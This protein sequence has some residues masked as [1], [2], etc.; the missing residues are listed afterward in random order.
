MPI[1]RLR[2]QLTGAA[3]VTLVLTVL[4]AVPTAWGQDVAG[5][6]EPMVPAK[7]IFDVLRQLLHKKSSEKAP[8]PAV[9][10]PG[11]TMAAYAPYIAANSSN[12]FIIGAAGN[13]AFFMGDPK[14][15]RLSTAVVS[16]S[17]TSKGQLLLSAKLAAFSKNN[18]WLLNGD[19]R[20]N[21]TSQKTY[22]LGTSTDPSAEVDTKYNFF[23]IYETLYRRVFPGFYAGAGFLFSSNTDV[24][25]AS[26]A[27]AV[28][29]DSPYVVY[30]EQNG[31]DLASQTSAGTSLNAVFDKRDS[32]IDP[33]RGWYAS[34]DYRFFFNGFL[35]GSSAWQEFQTDWR[36]YFRL[37]RDAR[38]KLGLWFYGDFVTQGTAPYYGLP[39]TG[40]DTYGRTGRGYLQGRYRGEEMVYGEIEYR[41]TIT[42]D[43]L[44]GLVVFLNT[45]T[46]SD[47]QAG[48]Q[49]FDSFA[50][51]GGFGLRVR[52]NK[53]SKTNV[54][55]DFGFGQK[56][57]SAFAIGVQEAF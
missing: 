55:F 32:S 45:E 15:T 5:Q 10:K 2:R 53:G 16:L 30:S 47:K 37:S 39:A 41:W 28:W 54:C 13:V 20:F 50:T 33:S 19:N 52:L 14:T 4:A 12:G 11:T 46:L 42:R 40:M 48:E 18:R 56:G 57:S 26:S 21:W 31:F 51:G 7:D 8:E 1:S 35:G 38:H 34:A 29:S 9:Q 49:L 44:L 23:R 17:Y 24:R 25:P 3:I 22:G 43:G 36:T 27:E 6:A